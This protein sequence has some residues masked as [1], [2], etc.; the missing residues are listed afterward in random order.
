MA[1]LGM[2]LRKFNLQRPAYSCC[3]SSEGRK[4]DRTIGGVKQAIN[5]RSAGVHT[6]RQLRLSNVR[7]LHFLRYLIGD[8]SFRRNSLGIIYETLI[9]EEIIKVTSKKFAVSHWGPLNLE[10]RSRAT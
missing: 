10:R 7:L 9:T 8:N 5:D 2:P 4:S 6:M 3:C 1:V